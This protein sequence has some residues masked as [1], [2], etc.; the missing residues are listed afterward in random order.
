MHAD[1]E[2]GLLSVP[3]VGIYEPI[4]KNYNLTMAEK[5]ALEIVREG[6]I[7]LGADPDSID[8][9]IVE[10]NSFNMVKGYSSAS[11]NIRVRAQVTPGLIYTL[12][13][14]K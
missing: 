13:G 12:E 8:A 10:S 14:E 6:A 9:E 7:Q 1:T 11:K 5:R 4:N 3:E 2:R